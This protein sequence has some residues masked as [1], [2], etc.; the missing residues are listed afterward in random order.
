MTIGAR[1]PPE[2]T[3]ELNARPARSRSPWPSQQM[4][5]GRPWNAMRSPAARIQRASGSFPGNSRSTASSVAAMS[6]GSPDSATHRNGP[7]PSQ[8]SGRM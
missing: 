4:R 6:R 7:L 1:T 5:A 2:A 8:N 3:R